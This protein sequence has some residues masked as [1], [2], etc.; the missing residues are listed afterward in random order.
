MVSH[1][2]NIAKKE[3]VKIEEEALHVI[4][5]KA[6]GAL[7]DALSCF[8]LMVNFCEGDISY[9]KVIQNLNILDHDYY[10]GLIDLVLENKIHESLLLFAEILSKGFDGKLFISGLATHLRNL[11]MSK[12]E[13]TLQILEYSSE[14]KDKFSNQASHIQ[15]DDITT[16][17]TLLSES[18]SSYKTSQNQRLLI[19]I[20]LM[21]L[22]SVQVQKKKS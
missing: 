15:A 13:R 18:E 21:Q 1:L 16:M 6:D 4:A 19:E 8:D 22:C 14:L 11:M 7:R 10:F 3:D 9:K 2:K 17:L 12:D 5:E 20:T